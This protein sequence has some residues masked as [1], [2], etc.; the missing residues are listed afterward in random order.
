VLV[1][2]VLVVARP[3]RQTS[4][5]RD[6]VEALAVACPIGRRDELESGQAEVAA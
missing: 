2:A 4:S 6:A 3:R 1:V 5:S